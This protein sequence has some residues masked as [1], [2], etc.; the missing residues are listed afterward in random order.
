M[1]LAFA[2]G[3]TVISAVPTGLGLLAVFRPYTLA[4][5]EERLDSIGSKRDW[6]TV[7]P[8]DWKVSLTRTQGGI[9]LLFGLFIALFA[10]NHWLAF[11]TAHTL[12]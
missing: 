9:L 11:F 7:E 2:I 10:V 12:T 5:W 6:E 1:S 8:T 4:L 3:Y